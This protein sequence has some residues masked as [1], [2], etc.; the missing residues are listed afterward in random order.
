[1]SFEPL[2]ADGGARLQSRI[3]A[4]FGQ[5]APNEGYTNAAIDGVRFI[6]TNRPVPRMPVLY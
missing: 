2:F 5:L 1:M 3:L 6:R 4:L